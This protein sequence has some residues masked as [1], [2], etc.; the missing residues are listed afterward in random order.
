MGPCLPHGVKM[1]KTGTEILGS[2]LFADM[3]A[4]SKMLRRLPKDV[5]KYVARLRHD[6]PEADA[7][8]LKSLAHS[9][10]AIEPLV[11]GDLRAI[12]IETSPLDYRNEYNCRMSGHLHE[13]EVPYSGDSLFWRLQH[14]TPIAFNYRGKIAASTV[15]LRTFI[16]GE[17]YRW[18][19]N[20][21]EKALLYAREMLAMTETSQR[22]LVERA[23]DMVER[24]VRDTL[25]T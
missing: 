8:Q 1:S 3:H 6:W 7:D 17:D 24:I 13:A 23:R 12:R 15:R 20:D 21:V 19:K 5:I 22:L 9:A 14:I 4:D 25:A 18:F 16:D 11:I 10:F 2:P